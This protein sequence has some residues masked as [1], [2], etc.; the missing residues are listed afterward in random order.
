MRDTAPFHRSTSLV[1]FVAALLFGLAL[2]PASTAGAAGGTAGGTDSSAS[3]ATT[4]ASVSAAPSARADRGTGWVNS[5][6]DNMTLQ[7]K[8]GQLFMTYAYG[9]TATTTAAADVAANQEAYGVDNASQLIDRYKLG[10]VIYFAW[11]NNVNNTEQIARLSNGIQDAALRQPRKI[12]SLISTD[13]EGGV[14]FRVP[15]T[16]LPGNMALGAGRSPQDAETAA[17]IG[18]SELKSVGVNWNFAPVADVNVNPANPVIGVRSFSEDPQLTAALT[19]AQVRGYQNQGIAAAAKHF[20]GHGDTATDSH[21]GL[22]TI[23]H[24]RAE[25]EQIDKPPFQAAIDQGI[26]AIMTAHIVVPSLDPSGDPATLSKPIMTG[27]LRN[28]MGYKGVVITDSL[29]MQGV[30]DKYGDDR[31]PVLAL[32]AGV[33]MLLMPP[34]LGLAYNSVLDAVQG[35]E[36]TESRIDTS[37]KRI[38]RLKWDLGLVQ[39]PYVDVA[40]ATEVTRSPAHLQ[41][42]QALTDR[43]PT[44][45]KNSG[46]LLPL[47]TTGQSVLVTGAGVAPT[48]IVADR[49]RARG[50][51][52]DVLETGT[53]PTQAKIDAAV[54]AAQTHDVTVVLTNRA[55]MASGA[56]QRELVRQLTATGKPVVAIA[57]RDAYDIAHFTEVPAYI[58]TYSYSGVSLESAVRVLYGEVNPQGKLPVTIPTAD[59]PGTA[60]YPFGYG[61]SY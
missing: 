3:K 32:K 20:P 48:A 43:T 13:Q 28:E 46:G 58:A 29:G 37:V 47:A 36:L 1:V 16:E 4:V 9:D 38:L 42:A 2:A 14:V 50:A 25:W 11:S 60:L 39:N 12:P 51:N 26:K 6:L 10:G 41:A 31:V 56:G 7:Q 17:V 8:V 34:N 35:G 52:A 61:L 18:G 21:T 22:P 44:L 23:D 15:A 40:H 5:T 30:R 45:V 53:N 27:I 54:A 33:D 55:W 49:M 59:D 57:I 24:T 19:A